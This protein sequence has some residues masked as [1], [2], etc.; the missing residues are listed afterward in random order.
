MF[1]I[2]SL[3]SIDATA[4]VRRRTR[5]WRRSRHPASDRSPT[6]PLTRATIVD[7]N[8][9]A[10]PEQARAW[11]RDLDP[12]QEADAAFAALNRLLYAHRIAAADPY[13]DA[14]T[15]DAATRLRAG[16]GTGEQV[17]SGRWSQARELYPPES[18]DQTR[19]RKRAAMLS[20]RREERFAALLAGRDRPL[21]CEELALRARLDLDNRRLA[22]ATIELER[23]V[24]AAISELTEEQL[25]PR[26][27]E[28]QALAPELTRIA[29]SVIAAGDQP[30]T[31]AGID[32]QQ[33]NQA[34]SRLEAAL[35]ARIATTDAALAPASRQTK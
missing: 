14:V 3:E 1:R 11:L 32:E 25:K 7:P 20:A 26:R 18:A 24:A 30:A 31:A 21:A 29:A 2:I 10:A 8:D 33:L 6:V 34:L 13:F 15:P 19:T 16:F 27:E 23:A 4:A 17:A 22:N 12:Q 35:R 28:L 5:R 9:F